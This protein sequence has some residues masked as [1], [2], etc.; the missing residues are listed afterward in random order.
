MIMNVLTLPDKIADTKRFRFIATS[1]FEEGFGM[2][3]QKA[4]LGFLV[5]LE[6]K[7]RC[8]L[9][10]GPGMWSDRISEE[11]LPIRLR[12]LLV[13]LGPTYVK[14]GQVLSLRPDLIPVEITKELSLLTNQVPPFSSETAIKI[15]E[16]ELEKPVE[17][18]FSHFDERPLAAGSL[19]QV[20]KA[21]LLNGKKVAVKIM[22]PGIE[23]TVKEDIHI[24]RF[25]ARYAET[26]I[27]EVQSI[28][29]VRLVEEFAE[30]INR[31]LDFTVEA[32]HA[33]RF[34]AMYAD[35]PAIKVAAIYRDYSSKRVLTMTLI[36]GIKLDDEEALTKTHIDK[37]TLAQNGVN[38]LL[39]QVFVEGF[40]HA[41]PHPGNYFALPENVFAFIDYGMAGRLSVLN[42][43]ELA[44]FFIS[45]L[46]QDS[47]SAIRHLWHLV[48][49]GPTA[50][51]MSFEHDT[52]DILHEWFGA[53][54]KDISLART[55]MRIM[56]SGRRNGIYFPANFAYLGKALLTTEA[57]GMSLD[58]E[59]DF[60]KQM[61]PYAIQILKKEVNPKN[62][63]Q[64]LQDTAL[65]YYSYLEQGPEQL[66]R[67]LQKVNSGEIGVKINQTELEEFTD[68]VSHREGR[69]MAVTLMN[70]VLFS[71]SV[72]YLAQNNFLN[73]HWSVSLTG[74]ILF[75][76][77]MVFFIFRK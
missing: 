1:I 38:A 34:G 29:P 25:F 3:L 42:R 72:L 41:D 14:F 31:E 23:K 26:H 32:T 22:R 36:D 7:V 53:K 46:N 73:L 21:T 48:E 39:Q 67:F 27:P 56:D 76:I 64:K 68:R 49:A 4:K 13:K 40:F 9:K 19:A 15:V 43:R 16:K 77:V 60:A 51:K 8:F 58:P 65:D 35:N 74:I 75:I 20:H 54:L 59:F 2:L 44:A 71:A 70:S 37:Q 24:L 28:R 6:C 45:F 11:E 18:L 17:K 10:Q 30:T 12:R 33:K 62:F 47:Q 50:N 55:F 5:P 69:K 61:K 57:M 63:K 52:D 66:M